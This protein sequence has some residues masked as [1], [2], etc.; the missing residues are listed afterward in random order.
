MTN[1]FYETSAND[2][3]IRQ[4]KLIYGIG[5]NDSDYVTRIIIRGKSYTCPFYSIWKAMIK[6]SYS[7]KYQEKNPSYKGCSVYQVWLLF[8][9]FK[10]WMETQ[11]WKGK[12]LDKDILVPGNKI[13]SPDLCVF[14]THAL[15]NLIVTNK[16]VRGG[17]PI[18]V[19]FIKAKKKFNA[20]VKI[21][22]KRVHLGYFNTEESASKAYNIAK[23]DHVA[24]IANKQKDER[25]KKGLLLHAELYLKGEVT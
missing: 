18:G 12:D 17:Y 1:L 19:C 23:H 4:R 15:N 6:R 11:D 7:I 24:R 2:Q 10:I 22:E 3:S 13:Y 16:L 21:N 9:N 14:V 25:V 20:R 8:S 5:V